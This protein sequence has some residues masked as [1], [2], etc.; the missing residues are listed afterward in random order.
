MNSI[1]S[2]SISEA[3]KNVSVPRYAFDNIDVSETHWEKIKNFV[4]LEKVIGLKT[5][6]NFNKR[7]HNIKHVEKYEECYEIEQRLD[8]YSQCCEKD[9]ILKNE[10]LSL[11]GKIDLPEKIFLSISQLGGVK[12]KEKIDFLFHEYVHS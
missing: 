1:K 4:T 7:C 3:L 8:G 5:L 9:I 12:L 10:Y 6:Y 2:L 11:V